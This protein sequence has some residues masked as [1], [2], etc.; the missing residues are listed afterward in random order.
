M[1]VLLLVL[2][3]GSVTTRVVWREPPEVP[4][5]VLAY[6]T[7]EWRDWAQAQTL[8]QKLSV[9]AEPRIQSQGYAGLAAVAFAQDDFQQAL[10]FATKAEAVDSEIVYSHVIR[11]HI[12]LTEGKIE[13]AKSS[14]RTAMNNTNGL[15][16]QQAIAAHHLGRIYADEGFYLDARKYY[17]R[18]ISQCP[19]MAAEWRQLSQD[20]A[21]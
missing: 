6:Q 11:G 10:E 16:C 8:F 21:K 3:A 20:K 17:D 15:P 4:S 5:S 12:Y 1:V 7:L 19:R 2:L 14:Y 9:Q 18:A 13:D